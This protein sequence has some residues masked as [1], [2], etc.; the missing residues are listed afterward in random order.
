MSSREGFESSMEE[1]ALS[2]REKEKFRR[3]FAFILLY[4]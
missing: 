3:G 4:F 1:D 2:P